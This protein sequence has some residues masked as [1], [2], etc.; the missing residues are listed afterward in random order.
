VLVT[1]AV[2]LGG[3][4]GVDVEMPGGEPRGA[5]VFSPSLEKTAVKLP[6]LLGSLTDKGLSADKA[7]EALGS[8]AW[9]GKDVDCCSDDDDGE[10]ASEKDVDSVLTGIGMTVKDTG[11]AGIPAVG[12]KLSGRDVG[13]V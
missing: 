8:S 4:M 11:I 12:R 5:S 10:G 9:A 3:I 6:N 1:G 7:A 2:E 13:C